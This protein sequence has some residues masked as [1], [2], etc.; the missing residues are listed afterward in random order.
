MKKAYLILVL[1]LLAVI[2]AFTY[3]KVYI[4]NLEARDTELKLRFERKALVDSLQAVH[5]RLV[6]S[7]TADLSRAYDSLRLESEQLIYALESQLSLQIDWQESETE[8][9]PP[10][11]SALAH[12]K[13][14]KAVVAGGSDMQPGEY[15]VYIEYLEK[16]LEFPGDLSAYER[17]V[18]IKE[19]KGNLRERFQLS[20]PELDSL[21]VRMRSRTGDESS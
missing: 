4:N 11:P 18:A 21:L 20:A 14:A 3:A 10:V 16:L 1:L 15:A 17:K 9:G 6:A 8:Y 2:A 12:D 5:S 13:S 7:E 19:L